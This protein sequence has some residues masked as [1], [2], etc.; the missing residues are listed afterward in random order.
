VIVLSTNVVSALMH[1][2]PA[3]LSRLRVSEP[4][5]VVLCSPVAA[6]I[7]YGLSR[8]VAGSRR[9]DML[10][11]EY[12]RLRDAVAWADW[13]EAAASEFGRQ[14]ARLEARGSTIEDMDIAIG[15]VARA[16]GARVATYNVRH[17]E[18]LEGLPI[19]DWSESPG[20]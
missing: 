15:S 20:S 11:E 19:D 12:A 5:D 1:R 2:I 8:L 9:R 18:R 14:K 17:L 3:A 4:V 13:T 10:A 6:E 16:L 7:H